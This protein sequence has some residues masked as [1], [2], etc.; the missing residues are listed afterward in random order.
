MFKTLSYIGEKFNYSNIEWAVGASM[1]LNQFGLINN[2]NDIDIFVDIKDINRANE[3]LR[4]IREKNEAG[5]SS[6]YSTKFFT[7]I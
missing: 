6:L 5:E 1:M 2:S 4:S 3:I 7:N